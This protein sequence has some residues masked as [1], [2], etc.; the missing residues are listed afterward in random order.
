ML[1]CDCKYFEYDRRMNDWAHSVYDIIE[2]MLQHTRDIVDLVVLSK[3]CSF[4]FS[5]EM[6]PILEVLSGQVYCNYSAILLL[7]IQ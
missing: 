5:A 3:H 4:P 2:Y 7:Y 6:D 1:K